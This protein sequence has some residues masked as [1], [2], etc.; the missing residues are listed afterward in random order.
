MAFDPKHNSR[1]I[2][3]RRDRAAA[4]A[5][6]Y[7]IG[8]TKEDIEKPFVGIANTWIGT[9]PCNFNP[10]LPRTRNVRWIDADPTARLRSH[11]KASMIA[12]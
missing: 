10:R 9:M 2:T 4:R 6:L 1:T 11:G 8:L 7:G 12:A 3:D 5:Y